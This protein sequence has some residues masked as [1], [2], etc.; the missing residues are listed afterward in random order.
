VDYSCDQIKKKKCNKLDKKTGFI[1]RLMC[2]E[3]C[4][5]CNDDDRCRDVDKKF[6]IGNNDKEYKRK[7]F[8]TVG[9]TQKKFTSCKKIDLNQCNSQSFKK[10]RNTKPNYFF[11]HQMCREKCG[12]CES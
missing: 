10:K 8:L 11:V 4:E 1:P 2:P 9:A 12:F 7:F 3:K 5:S 6:T